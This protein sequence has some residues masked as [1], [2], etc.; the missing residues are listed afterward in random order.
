MLADTRDSWIVVGVDTHE[1]SHTYALLDMAGRLVETFQL[2]AT[3]AGYRQAIERAERWSIREWS[4]EGT[5]SYG[6][7]LCD[8]L[9]AYAYHVT[10]AERP[11][12]RGR[13]HGAKDDVIDAVAAAKGALAN[14]YRSTPRTRTSTRQTLRTLII[15]RD[16]AV[17]TYTDATRQLKALVVTAPEPLRAALRGLTAKQLWIACARLPD[18][19]PDQKTTTD[20]LRAIGQRALAAHTEAT[21]HHRNL[22]TIIQGYCPQLLDQHG[23]GP[24]SAAH[25]L[26]AWSH[27]QRLRS[28]ACFARLAG[29][30]PIP[31]SS[32]NTTRHRLDRGGDRQLNNAI[33]TIATTRARTDQ[34]T[35][36]YITR[37]RAEGK[38]RREAIRAVKRH[39]ARNIYRLLEATMT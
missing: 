6:A 30:A 32:G 22:T 11:S 16:G 8:A 23:I 36:D 9:F 17:R 26:I 37:R 28:E 12:R 34:R 15:A 39:I 31:A 27:P 5:G 24:I 10:E 21:R 33:H 3:A 18:T 13:R 1:R 19:H 25:I 2:P 20:T 14:T 29:V 38:T 4:V 7:G 35:I